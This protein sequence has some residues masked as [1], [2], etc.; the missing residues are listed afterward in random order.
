MSYLNIMNVLRRVHNLRFNSNW[1]LSV[2]TKTS[3]DL[4]PLFTLI[5]RKQSK[6][7]KFNSNK[8]C[9][10]K[11]VEEKLALVRIMRGVVDTENVLG[12]WIGGRHMVVWLDKA[13]YDYLMGVL[14]THGNDTGK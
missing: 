2:S 7:T 1:L 9:L 10:Q 6:S 5:D 3:G 14:K 13:E 11:S 4:Y 8:H 12:T